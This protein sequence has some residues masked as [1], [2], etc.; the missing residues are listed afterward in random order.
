MCGKDA[1]MLVKTIKQITKKATENQ[2]YL[3]III[4]FI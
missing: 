1:D 2:E 3:N 4:K